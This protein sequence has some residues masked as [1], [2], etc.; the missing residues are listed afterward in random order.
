VGSVA[1]IG[2]V[3][4]EMDGIA[5]TI[6]ETV[7]AQSRST[8]EIARCVRQAVDGMQD[9]ASN[10]VGVNGAADEAGQAA[11]RASAAA[12]HL[13]EQSARLSHQVTSFLAQLRAA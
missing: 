3:I 4:R 2:A 13:R 11:D 7:D 6:A 1:D 5:S 8:E 9:T 12:Q 10:I